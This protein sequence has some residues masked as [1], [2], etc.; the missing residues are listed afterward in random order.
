MKRLGALAAAIAT[1]TLPAPAL[2]W[3]DEGHEVVALIA[4][5]YLAPPVL[6]RV[7]QLLAEDA[8]PLTAPDMASRA[9]WADKYREDHRS[10]A[11][12]HYANLELGRPD[13]E[14][15]CG[16]RSCAP[17]KV[18]QFAAELASPRTPE[19]EK[20]FALKMVLHLV[21]DL[22]QPLHAAEA[23]SGREGDAGGNCERVMVRGFFGAGQSMSLHAF[24]DRTA[25]ERL[26]RDPRSVA[27][28]LRRQITARQVLTWS[29]GSPYD[30]TME[31]HDLAESVAYRFGGPPR[32]GGYTVPLSAEYQARAQNAA[33]VQ[34]QKAGVRLATVLNR[35]LG[36]SSVK[37]GRT[38]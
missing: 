2:A 37:R 31:A 22:H 9:T 14:E 12:W 15:A 4:R 26:G 29:Q 23:G 18:D 10:S 11:P 16:R 7:D 8:D 20:I 30:W 13:I 19:A 27:T 36:K 6:Q 21:G 25:V 5:T 28:R 24:W 32:C 3:G 17:Q 1:T 34:L 33:A 38:G 35:S